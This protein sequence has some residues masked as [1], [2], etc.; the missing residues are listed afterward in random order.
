VPNITKNTLANDMSE[1]V[2]FRACLML[3]AGRSFLLCADG[4]ANFKASLQAGAPIQH[5]CHLF[6]AYLHHKAQILPVIRQGM[7]A[8]KPQSLGVI[9]GPIMC[10]MLAAQ[11]I[12]E[13]AEAMAHLQGLFRIIQIY[14]SVT[15]PRSHIIAFRKVPI[16]L[17]CF[18][19]AAR[20]SATSRERVLWT[21][22]F[23]LF[24][25]CVIEFRRNQT[26]AYDN[27]GLGAGSRLDAPLIHWLQATLEAKR[28]GGDG[29]SSQG[30]LRSPHASADPDEIWI[31]TKVAGA[32]V[33]LMGSARPL[34]AIVAD[35]VGLDRPSFS[36]DAYAAKRP[37]HVEAYAFMEEVIENWQRY[38]NTAPGTTLMDDGLWRSFVERLEWL[39]TEEGLELVREVCWDMECQHGRVNGCVGGGA[40]EDVGGGHT[41]QTSSVDCLHC[42]SIQVGLPPSQTPPA[43]VS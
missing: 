24:S 36:Y 33:L 1:P 39:E 43:W 27:I 17:L 41:C 3:A 25:H 29:P 32:Y 42:P 22:V 30:R 21:E 31:W 2:W 19:L 26:P 4:P 12:G 35:D 18:L 34:G 10:L 38:A 16:I 23:Y 13:E 7:A 11:A 5:R 8:K 28:R 6:H 9:T 15:G 40:A 20:H 14:R 37:R